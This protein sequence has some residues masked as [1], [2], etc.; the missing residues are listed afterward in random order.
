[1]LNHGLPSYHVILAAHHDWVLFDLLSHKV[2]CVQQYSIIKQKWFICDQDRAGPEG[3][4]KLHE[5]VAQMPMVSTSITPPSI[6][7][8]TLKGSW[9]VPT[10]R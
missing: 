7:W 9:G 5:E 2:G 6:Y 1:M 10:I 3:K 8:H 4:S